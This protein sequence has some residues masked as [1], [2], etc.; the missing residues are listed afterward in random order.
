MTEEEAELMRGFFLLTSKP[1]IYVANVGEDE[2]G[3][4][5]SKHVNA[6]YEIAKAEKAEALTICCKL[7]EEIT[8]LDPA[9]K[10][11]FLQELGIKESGLDQLV[12][13]CYR[14][15]GLISY[16]TAGPKEVRAWTIPRG[17]KA[18]QRRAKSTPTL[19]KASFA[20]RSCR[21]RRWRNSLHC[22][23]QGKR[24]RP[25]RGQGVRHAGRGRNAVPVQRVNFTQTKKAAVRLLFC[26][27]RVYSPFMSMTLAFCSMT[28][29]LSATDSPMALSMSSASRGAARSR[30]ICR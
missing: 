9:E 16:L 25:Q 21:L 23:L 8:A 29:M 26:N 3:A 2:I 6:L 7:E 5:P 18:P 15:L 17:T 30:A 11:A 10:T 19:K 12:K 22:G 27:K 28:S 13:A 1:I 4:E 24:P 14:L 20:R